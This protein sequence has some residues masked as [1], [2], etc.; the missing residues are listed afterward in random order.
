M[1][2]KSLRK[3]WEEKIARF[4]QSGQSQSEWCRQNGLNLRTFNNWY[5]KLKKQSKT[6]SKPV[7]WIPVKIVE[8][9]SAEPLK[10]KIGSAVIEVTEGFDPKLLAEVAKALGAAC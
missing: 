4:K 2:N 3:D 10:I 8:K 5:N 6:D 1:A 9:S 7:S